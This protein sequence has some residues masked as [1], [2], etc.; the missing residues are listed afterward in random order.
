MTYPTKFT[1]YGQYWT[2]L[3]VYMD[4]PATPKPFVLTLEDHKK[5]IAKRLEFYAYRGAVRRDKHR[6][7]DPKIANAFATLEGVEVRVKGNVLEFSLKDEDAVASA[8]NKAF[9]KAG[10]NPT[11]DGSGGL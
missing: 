8:F 9:A 1:R 10:Y 11:K 6:H 3:A 2:D 5:A 4:D 7:P